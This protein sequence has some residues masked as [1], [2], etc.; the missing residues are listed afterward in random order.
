LTTYR[1]YIALLL[2]IE[3]SDIKTYINKLNGHLVIYGVIQ[4]ISLYWGYVKI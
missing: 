3:K 2:A 1:T 4:N